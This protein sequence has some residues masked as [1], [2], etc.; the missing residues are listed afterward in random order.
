MLDPGSTI[1]S[2]W[3]RG[4]IENISNM[5][6]FIMVQCNVCNT[7]TNHIINLKGFGEAW[8]ISNGISN[9]LPPKEVRKRFNMTYKCEANCKILIV[10]TNHCKFIFKKNLQILYFH[11]SV[12]RNIY[13]V[14]TV[15]VN[16]EVFSGHQREW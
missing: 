1:S 5:D 12:N 9:I 7:L 3:F 13:T 15:T 8:L 16:Q 4:L 11:D 2:F 6:K 10:K 14:N